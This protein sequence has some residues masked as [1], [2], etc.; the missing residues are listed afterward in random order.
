LADSFWHRSRGVYARCLNWA[1]LRRANALSYTTFQLVLIEGF[2]SFSRASVV[3][4]LLTGA[5]AEQAP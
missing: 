3:V 2:F 1:R 5:L 4:N